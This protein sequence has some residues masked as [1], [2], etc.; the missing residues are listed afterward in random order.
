MKKSSKKKNLPKQVKKRKSKR[1]VKEKVIPIGMTI[2]EIYKSIN[3][4]QLKNQPVD[5]QVEQSLG[6]VVENILKD[7][8][9]SYV[10]KNELNPSTY[11]LLRSNKKKEEIDFNFQ[12]MP[13]EI[14][15]DGFCF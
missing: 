8:D 11:S 13:D 12:E 3:F 2:E 14:T 4:I 6:L 9:I 7:C 10:K 1:R 5:I 15:E